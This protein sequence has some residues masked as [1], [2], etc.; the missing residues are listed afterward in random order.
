[1]SPR[2]Q[3]VIIITIVV[4]VKRVKSGVKG[5]FG[6]GACGGGGWQGAMPPICQILCNMTL[7]QHD[8]GVHMASNYAFHFHLA[9]NFRLC[10]SKMLHLLACT[11]R[12]ATRSQQPPE[13]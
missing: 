7:K 2:A 10:T 3:L 1:M 4:V 11:M 8:A 5:G 12:S 6:G 13:R 9:L